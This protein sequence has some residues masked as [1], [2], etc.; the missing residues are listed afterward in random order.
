VAGLA[1]VMLLA[2]GCATPDGSTGQDKQNAILNMRYDTLNTL[3][4]QQPAA[5]NEIQAAPGY[6][7]FSNVGVS[8]LILGTGQGYGV[9]VDNQKKQPTYMKMAQASVG[10]GIG[11]KDFRAVFVFRDR[12]TMTRFVDN[13]W[14]F[15]G[16]AEAGVKSGDK[17]GEVGGADSFKNGI[18]VYQMTEAGVVLRAAVPMTKYWRYDELN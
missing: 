5:R 11:L 10:L 17:G 6:A 18:K 15:G 16:E 1:A 3:F 8:V 7:V 14:E 13:G 4:Q 12:E 2:G 9:V